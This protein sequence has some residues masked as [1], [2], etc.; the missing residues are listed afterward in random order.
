MWWLRELLACFRF[1]AVSGNRSFWQSKR[2]YEFVLPGAVTLVFL[3][4]YE[5]VPQVFHAGFLG[6]FLGLLFQFM[7]FVVPFHLAALAAFATFERA[8]L[9]EPLPGTDAEIMVWS[10]EDNERV[11]KRLTLRQY[12]SLLF[13]YLCSIGVIF[14][15]AYLLASNL[16]L[17]FV[18]GT[19]FGGVYSVVAVIMLFFVAHYAILTAYSITFLFEKINKIV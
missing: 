1:L 11:A 13:G 10:N 17:R 19:H 18:F 6:R 8:G 16:D 9:D 4:I 14:I 7:V 3:I 12:A 5:A 15:V 2:I